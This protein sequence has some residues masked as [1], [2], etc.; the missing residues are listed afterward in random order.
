MWASSLV[1]LMFLPYLVMAVVYLRLIFH[2]LFARNEVTYPE[3]T[4][5]YSC[6]MAFRTGKLYSPPF[7]FP[8]N[9]EIFGPIYYWAGSVL[10]RIAHGDALTTLILCRLLSFGSYLGSAACVGLIC[11]HLEKKKRWAW[12]AVVLGLACLWAVRWAGSARPD[13]LAAFFILLALLI[14]LRA[15]GNA[16]VVSVAAL[17]ASLSWL[18]KQTTGP[19]LVALAIDCLIGRRWKQVAA[20]VLG[21]VPVPAVILAVLWFRKEPFL[22]NFLASR[23]VVTS[24]S[25]PLEGLVYALRV[26]SVALIP[27]C[28]ALLGAILVW[29]RANYRPILL[30]VLIGGA[31]NLAAMTNVGANGNYLILPWLL[32]LLLV[33]AGLER[34]EQWTLRRAWIPVAFL[35]AG[36]LL[37][38]HRS[39]LLFQVFPADL[40]TSQVSKLTMLSDQSYLEMQSR[41]PQL[42]D[43]YTYG[44]FSQRKV[45]DEAPILQRID[46][47]YYDLIL[48]RADPDFDRWAWDEAKRAE[49]AAHY[50]A[51][52]EVQGEIGLVPRSRPVGVQPKDLARIFHEPCAA[53][54]QARN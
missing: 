52:C 35:L 34:I 41:E 8:F 5:V 10:A 16:W 12:V 44:E 13:M 4:A 45:W 40:D 27:G 30:V 1:C 43:P 3:G 29:R 42:L 49:M 15:E 21:S 37:L 6:L 19:V 2:Y 48:M 14:Y 47:E 26:N 23:N 46:R 11:L 32:I 50:V 54:A 31:A 22:A 20:L 24:W 39:F 28:V 17:V 7:Q 38:F 36:I 25:G 33:P 53:V 9:V 51:V 18:T